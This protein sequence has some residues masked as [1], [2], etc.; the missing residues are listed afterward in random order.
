VS[1]LVRVGLWL[2]A[3][4]AVSGWLVMLRVAFPAILTRLGVRSPRRV[5]QA[6]IDFVVMGVIL[7]AVGLALP[8]LAGWNRALLIFGAVVNP[9]L[10]VPLA[11][12][13]GFAD[14]VPYR[15]VTVVSFSAMSVGTV[16]AAIA[17]T[18]G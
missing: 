4:G 16:G 5:L 1:V 12:R 11:F 8:D 3:V 2:L 17:G 10:F 9:A 14:A 18:G 7:I 13:E 15:I 6:H